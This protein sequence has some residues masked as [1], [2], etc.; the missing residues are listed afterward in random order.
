MFPIGA[1]VKPDRSGHSARRPGTAAIQV[2]LDCF[3]AGLLQRCGRE[4]C[5]Q[6]AAPI[7]TEGASVYQE[8]A[9]Q[10]PV[11]R[12]E[13]MPVR[14]VKTLRKPRSDALRNRERLL[15]AAKAVF[16]AGGPDASLEA[17]ARRAD[18][19]IGTLYRHFP[20]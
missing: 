7:Y 12:P 20:T 5:A 2:D 14:S 3:H 6:R 15:A 4:A 17:V 19:G 9:D 18:V 13:K 1:I 10:Q 11:T 8:A 16:S